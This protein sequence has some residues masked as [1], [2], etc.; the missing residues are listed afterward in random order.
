[1]SQCVVRGEGAVFD[2]DAEAATQ[3]KLL[4]CVFPKLFI[5]AKRSQPGSAAAEYAQGFCFNGS[6][7]E[8]T[9][10]DG[11]VVSAGASNEQTA[12]WSSNTW[13]HHFHDGSHV[14][15]SIMRAC[16]EKDAIDA[17]LAKAGLASNRFLEQLDG[18][19]LK[20]VRRAASMFAGKG[21]VADAGHKVLFR[22]S[23]DYKQLQ[24][25]LR[26]MAVGDIFYRNHGWAQETTGHAIVHLYEKTSP[27]T[28]SMIACNSG[29]GLGNHPGCL[30]QTDGGGWLGNY[31]TGKAITGIRIDNIDMTTPRWND[32]GNW[33]LIERCTEFGHRLHGS[34][35]YA[36]GFTYLAAKTLRR[37]IAESDQNLQSWP[38]VGQRGPT[39]GF[40]GPFKAHLYLH[41]RFGLTKSDSKDATYVGRLFF[42]A[43]AGEQL[44]AVRHDA[45]QSD[46]PLSAASVPNAG[47]GGAKWT[48]AGMA[49]PPP[50]MMEKLGKT[51]YLILDT[52]CA[53][54][55][56]AG[57]KL[58]ERGRL[59]AEG[60]QLCVALVRRVRQL[61]PGRET[62][63]FALPKPLGEFAQADSAIP[64]SGPAAAARPQ[65][66]LLLDWDKLASD[67][68][69]VEKLAGAKTGAVYPPALDVAAAVAKLNGA[70]MLG[71]L[72]DGLEELVHACD[73]MKV[74]FKSEGLVAG[75]ALHTLALLHDV[76]LAGKLPSPPPPT[77]AVPPF[78]AAKG[79]AWT[80]GVTPALQGRCT[81][82][83]LA[84]ACE[85]AASSRAS[86]R[87]PT[88]RA[89]TLIA[90]G[91]IV[92]AADAVVCSAEK[93]NNGADVDAI[94]AMQWTTLYRIL[95]LKSDSSSADHP[96]LFANATADAPITRSSACVVRAQVQAYFDAAATRNKHG[97]K[98]LDWLVETDAEKTVCFRIPE[99][100]SPLEPSLQV[101]F[102]AAQ[103]LGYH[104]L[105]NLKNK[106]KSAHATQGATKSR[107]AP[108]MPMS[109]R[110]G[111]YP[112]EIIRRV[113]ILAK[114]GSE[115]VMFD[116]IPD[117]YCVEAA[118]HEVQAG[119]AFGT[120]DDNKLLAQMPALCEIRDLLLLLRISLEP[121][122]WNAQP[123][124]VNLTC[125]GKLTPWKRIHARPSLVGYKSH[126]TNDGIYVAR[127]VGLVAFN[128]P[129]QLGRTAQRG[130][131]SLD[132]PTLYAGTKWDPTV[133]AKNL[134]EKTEDDVLH[135]EALPSFGGNLS[136]EEVENLMSFLAVP[137]LRV[138]LVLSFFAA[139]GRLTPLFNAKLKTMLW[140]AVF[141][142][143]KWRPSDDPAK[144]KAPSALETFPPPSPTRLCV[145]QGYLR[146][147]LRTQPS[148]V[149]ASTAT[150]L[151]NGL[152]VARIGGISTPYAS[153][154]LFVARLATGVYEAAVDVLHAAQVMGADPDA[155][156]DGLPDTMP[157]ATLTALKEGVAM[158]RELIARGVKGLLRAWISEASAVSE[159]RSFGDDDDADFGG[160][161]L[162]PQA[163]AA[164]DHARRGEAQ[165][166][167]LAASAH[168]ALVSSPSIFS[169]AKGKPTPDVAAYVRFGA[170]ENEGSRAVAELLGTFAY[171]IEWFGKGLASKLYGT[172]SV[173]SP[174][175]PE[176]GGAPARKVWSGSNALWTA[177][178]GGEP[179]NG[180]P[181]TP[182]GALQ[183]QPL[184]FWSSLASRRS[185]LV[186]WF[187]NVGE[188]ERVRCLT[189]VMQ[190]ALGDADASFETRDAGAPNPAN[191]ADPSII[192]PGE[193]FIINGRGTHLGFKCFPTE[194]ICI[195]SKNRTHS[196]QPILECEGKFEIYFTTGG[197]QDD[198]ENADRWHMRNLTGVGNWL[199][200]WTYVGVGN[201]SYD[202]IANNWGG[203]E[204]GIMSVARR[205]PAAAGTRE[206]GFFTAGDRS[207]YV[208]AQFASLTFAAGGAGKV[209][210]PD[211]IASDRRFQS[212][213]R[214]ERGGVDS[215]VMP[216]LLLVD[217][218]ERR[219]WYH[220]SALGSNDGLE[221][222]LWSALLDDSFSAKMS[223]GERD[224][225][226]PDASFE[227]TDKGGESSVTG[228]PS[229]G[230]GGVVQYLGGKYG[231]VG[232][233]FRAGNL[234]GL[235]AQKKLRSSVR[236]ARIPGARYS[237]DLGNVAPI[238]G[239]SSVRSAGGQHFQSRK[240]LG[241][242]A[243]K[244]L[245]SLVSRC[246]LPLGEK[247][248]KWRLRASSGTLSGSE[249]QIARLSFVGFDN[250]NCPICESGTLFSSG[251]G[252]A[253]LG[254]SNA[255]N[256]QDR[257]SYWAGSINAGGGS[258]FY[259]GKE[260]DEE[261]A[262]ASV[263]L[264]QHIGKSALAALKEG[265][266][267][268]KSA[269]NMLHI[270]TAVSLE[271]FEGGRWKLSAE[272]HSLPLDGS[273]NV[274][275][276][277]PL[278]NSG[279]S[280]GSGSD[281]LSQMLDSVAENWM[282]ELLMRCVMANA[283]PSKDFSVEILAPAK[284]LSPSADRATLLMRDGLKP[285][286]AQ[287]AVIQLDRTHN[288][289]SVLGL[290][291]YGR[292][293]FPQL[294]WTSDYRSCGCEEGV[295]PCGKYT[296]QKE[297]LPHPFIE[298]QGGSFWDDL[299][300]SGGW[301][302]G[303]EPHSS[304]VVIRTVGGQQQQLIPTEFLTGIVLPEALTTAFRFW[305]TELSEE[306]GGAAMG[307]IVAQKLPSA[308]ESWFGYDL[309]LRVAMAGDAPLSMSTEELR[310]LN[311][312]IEL[313]ERRVRTLG[314]SGD[315]KAKA[316]AVR[317]LNNMKEARRMAA[318][319]PQ[320][321]RSGSVRGGGSS[322]NV[323]DIVR[324]SPDVADP[325]K[326]VRYR[327]V[328]LV[329]P[330]LNPSGWLAQVASLLQRI[331]NLA[332]VLAWA[333]LPS[334]QKSGGAVSASEAE[335][336]EVERV[337]A[338]IE[339]PRLQL[340]FTAKLDAQKRV[341]L[342]SAE[343][344]GKFIVPAP[345][346]D[347]AI[348]PETSAADATDKGLHRLCSVTPY[349]LL[350]GDDSGA[351]WLLVPNCP[352]DPEAY[353]GS[354]PWSTNLH[355]CRNDA[356]WLA[357]FNTRCYL[358]SIPA[359]R[360]WLEMPS[361]EAAL[362]WSFLLVVDRRYVECAQAIA[363]LGCDESLSDQER[364]Q[365]KRWEETYG[366]KDSRNVTA[367]RTKLWLRFRHSPIIKDW[368]W[369]PVASKLVPVPATPAPNTARHCLQR[370]DIHHISAACRLSF[371]DERTL[372]AGVPDAKRATYLDE[373]TSGTGGT[374]S[375][376]SQR[377][378]IDAGA[379][380]LAFSAPAQLA[381]VM[382][383]A[384]DMFKEST[385]DTDRNGWTKLEQ[386]YFNRERDQNAEFSTK[387]KF[388][389]MA[390][391][392][393]AFFKEQTQEK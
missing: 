246:S 85:L 133:V 101:F 357:T 38:S 249:W 1:M 70:T 132:H 158:L 295:F 184:A 380:F 73:E 321:E 125:Q 306:D 221:L 136:G 18:Q 302:R 256:S 25:Q 236:A 373:I 273:D 286:W 235:A 121:E 77:C 202:K 238:G 45:G 183:M 217:K 387:A 322:R 216:H 312:Q 252:N 214:S 41:K 83:L 140:S 20:M 390:E 28:L 149:L 71:G 201:S 304:L 171:T 167:L 356:T 278:Q 12:A 154:F 271:Y 245:S 174:T 225:L 229:V 135:A 81:A 23:S 26:D 138:P 253:A 219:S 337:V 166:M 241:E 10:F 52:A 87:E 277:S 50:L 111:D 46:A 311:Q 74:R 124:G 176:W 291:E 282:A 280:A 32:L 188:D 375:A 160:E 340:R 234:H 360:L 259:L 210:M 96:V 55:A 182:V 122:N 151:A 203:V 269:R 314:K 315:A 370:K 362:L 339:L 58:H 244:W 388:D 43:K 130:A 372:M 131:A 68:G 257:D 275:S 267:A 178:S 260:Y 162:S 95:A 293:A 173:P 2:D 190:L 237:G 222:K 224:A 251:A 143:G 19:K 386:T 363:C 230:D 348:D 17:R 307:D 24:Q 195:A 36:Y 393:A 67:F 355:P 22:E 378:G 232:R 84:L 90:I 310:D 102:E 342:Y 279:L 128:R 34:M 142:P 330:D 148:M 346:G 377:P 318:S 263:M 333:E 15:A 328:D 127:L 200:G 63:Y 266:D 57:M 369:E 285:S 118:D 231:G 327:L 336:D 59:S 272:F 110:A 194:C 367:L 324:S 179:P 161:V 392:K 75:G 352:Q 157:S 49:L 299:L 152:R 40:R 265:G 301:G 6:N 239:G 165:S 33:H 21:Y 206:R 382:K 349:S 316:R 262:V 117:K 326:M 365:L 9:M 94:K 39:C 99:K 288:R 376:V 144:P 155:R 147:E 384:T 274:D 54:L 371:D 37:A 146:A 209:R 86:P 218:R 112:C 303:A 287:W 159:G 208:D 213:M 350:L 305:R 354:A 247:A 276:L 254:E 258:D 115:N 47:F 334:D 297:W 361:L 359:H 80:T 170:D 153:T 313:S 193:L 105:T 366:D 44:A 123:G 5:G 309:E 114:A 389:N 109:G 113:A 35:S 98:F 82:A 294:V 88:N 332:Y 180:V 347:D 29:A 189:G 103:Q 338:L 215:I 233:T 187:E 27:T 16:D 61:M 335:A 185:A 345:G 8:V 192:L 13:G 197:N 126:L 240:S 364:F 368:P 270:A 31:P 119:W 289:A 204:G 341:R 268:A 319:A 281:L 91:F 172:P 379:D 264:H 108:V 383:R 116:G 53:E 226:N 284:P 169:V 228:L 120:S 51:E 261:V 329:A 220:M 106:W 177:A 250:P 150:I 308:D 7:F 129:W 164:R 212:Y 76:F 242:K 139:P 198:V 92:A 64:P 107:D 227:L 65:L 163:A 344:S 323:Y 351:R 3:E 205:P 358:Y 343:H 223:A 100:V 207:M 14:S 211:T 255:I 385:T 381:V 181:D 66:A 137:S 156:L 72:V 104:P 141:A 320:L 175:A 186:Q 248:K 89:M 290:R 325:S 298:Y 62:Y 4:R 79:C 300:D 97:K 374:K 56:I 191:M 296:I 60:M 199:L 168:L 134:P 48:G 243:K 317:A 42:L 11:E 196:G 93:K 391:A 331:E 145:R 353:I 283:K 69:G 78:R 30:A 292:R